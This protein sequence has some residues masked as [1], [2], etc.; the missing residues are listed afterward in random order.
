MNRPRMRFTILGLM[1]TVAVVGL[2]LTVVVRMHPQP[3]R[4]QIIQ[5]PEGHEVTWSDG[6]R[7][8]IGPDAPLPSLNGREPFAFGFL[9]RVKWFDGTHTSY[10]WHTSW[11]SEPI[12]NPPPD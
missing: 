3:V 12:P 4:V 1:F 6:S 10:T 2:L 5:D 9:R 8:R 7:T 11:T